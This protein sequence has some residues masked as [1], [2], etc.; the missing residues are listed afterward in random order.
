V[1]TTLEFFAAPMNSRRSYSKN[2]FGRIGVPCT[3]IARRFTNSLTDFN[4][5][6][7]GSDCRL[8]V[9]CSLPVVGCIISALAR[10][11]TLTTTPG[12]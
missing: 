6:L 9:M 12:P 2:K 11:F 3:A 1:R 4:W 10:S 8:E 7:V 5:W